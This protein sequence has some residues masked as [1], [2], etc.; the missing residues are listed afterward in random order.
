M[1]ELFGLQ[2][3][4]G[5]CLFVTA[6]FVCGCEN[7][8]S[9]ESSSDLIFPGDQF[10]LAREFLVQ[11]EGKHAL[12]L[13]THAKFEFVGNEGAETGEGVDLS[14]YK[15]AIGGLVWSVLRDLVS[16][17][18]RDD[19]IHI[20]RDELVLDVLD[21]LTEHE[22]R[23]GFKSDYFEV[24]KII[25]PREL[26]DVL[27]TR[28]EAL[29]DEAGLLEDEL[30]FLMGRHQTLS[31]LNACENIN[32]EL[33]DEMSSDFDSSIKALEDGRR[34][35]IEVEMQFERMRGI[36]A[37]DPKGKEYL[38]P[39]LRRLDEKIQKSKD[40][41]SMLG[42][43]AW[44]KELDLKTAKRLF[45]QCQ[46]SQKIDESTKDDINLFMDRLIEDF[47]SKEELMMQYAKRLNEMKGYFFDAPIE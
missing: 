41:E 9:T 23:L 42:S 46:K 3:L 19:L 39:D 27:G 37:A 6:F 24:S 45:T 15:D 12:T 21:G 29:S 35:A 1:V 18:T 34:K 43:N 14:R 22:S 32:L 40:L 20:T 8:E 11:T 31:K 33:I 2:R 36:Y 10:Q 17:L 28:Y 4:A 26:L 30:N 5:A 7:R 13:Y 44:A 38:V 25:P 47:D 16:E